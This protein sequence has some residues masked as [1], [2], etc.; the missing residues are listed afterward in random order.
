[1]ALSL[2]LS[3]LVYSSSQAVHWSASFSL[4]SHFQTPPYKH[5]CIFAEVIINKLS[6]SY[7]CIISCKRNL[8]AS[9]TSV[10]KSFLS[11]YL[12]IPNAYQDYIRQTYAAPFLATSTYIHADPVEKCDCILCEYSKK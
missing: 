5:T 1:V 10:L 6:G 2:S 7:Y 8:Q 4:R 9:T 11:T 3:A 12:H